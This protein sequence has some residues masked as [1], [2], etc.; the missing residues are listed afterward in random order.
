MFVMNKRTGR[1]ILTNIIF[2][3]I[4][5]M[6]ARFFDKQQHIL[7]V[8]DG[9]PLVIPQLPSQKVNGDKTSFIE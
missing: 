9:N 3:D 5:F 6:Y 4:D 8:M 7:F 2:A 1:T